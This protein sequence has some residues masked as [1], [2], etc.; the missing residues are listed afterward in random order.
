VQQV[1]Y[2]EEDRDAAGARG[3]LL[4]DAGTPLEAGKAGPPAFERDDLAVDDQ[5]L[6]VLCR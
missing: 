6:A 2:V 3:G 4:V 5:S 1:E